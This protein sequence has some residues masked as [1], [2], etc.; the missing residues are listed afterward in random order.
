MQ[1]LLHFRICMWKN[2]IRN[3][4]KYLKRTGKMVEEINEDLKRRRGRSF[5]EA[6]DKKKD[7]KR[8]IQIIL[9]LI[10]MFYI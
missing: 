9:N 10:D 7:K 5:Q 4:V 6:K 3:K 1:Q 8:S 2:I